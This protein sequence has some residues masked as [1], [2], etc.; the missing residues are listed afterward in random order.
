[1]SLHSPDFSTESLVD[2]GHIFRNFCHCAQSS[3]FRVV[4][5]DIAEWSS[6]AKCL[7]QIQLG[8]SRIRVT[9][10]VDSQ[11]GVSPHYRSP[12]PSLVR[13][14][15]NS[16]P[17]RLCRNR[18]HASSAAVIK[19]SSCM[20]GLCLTCHA[21]DPIHSLTTGALGCR[22]GVESGSHRLPGPRLPSA[23]SLRE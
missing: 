17:T 6:D 20:V 3:T 12:D 10:G 16:Q 4:A 8:D 1:M 19:A 21:M 23:K 14:L 15:R 2:C 5:I 22:P 13:Y 9:T 7:L 18:Q 11:Y